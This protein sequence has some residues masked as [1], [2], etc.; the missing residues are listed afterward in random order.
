MNRMMPNIGIELNRRKPS[1]CRHISSKQALIHEHNAIKCIDIDRIWIERILYGHPLSAHSS[2]SILSHV[3]LSSA[4]NVIAV[5]SIRCL[6]FFTGCITKALKKGAC[7]MF[8]ILCCCSPSSKINANRVRN[9]SFAGRA[10]RGCQCGLFGTVWRNWSISWLCLCKCEVY[11]R[12]RIDE[13]GRILV[14]NIQD[15]I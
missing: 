2:W 10:Y 6:V 13:G 9:H 15:D 4:H 7:R 11:M 8:V 5:D 14:H 12:H 3:I 1:F